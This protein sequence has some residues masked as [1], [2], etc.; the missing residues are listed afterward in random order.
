MRTDSFASFLQIS[1]KYFVDMTDVN[2]PYC[3]IVNY[4]MWSFSGSFNT[5]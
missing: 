2:I 1:Q 5:K 3:C 4:Q